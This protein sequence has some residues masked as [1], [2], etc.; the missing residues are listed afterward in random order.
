MATNPHVL[1]GA[2]AVTAAMVVALPVAKAI[3]AAM[4]LPAPSFKVNRAT[5]GDLLTARRSAPKPLPAHL[6]RKPPA[7]PNHQKRQQIMDGCDPLFSPVAVP[8]MAHVAGRC[9][10]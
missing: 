7:D 1:I 4:L 6:M 9:V 2:L 5:K 3:D 8:S 10:G